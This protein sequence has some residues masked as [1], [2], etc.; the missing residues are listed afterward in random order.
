MATCNDLAGWGILMPQ[1]CPLAPGNRPMGHKPPPCVPLSCP[2]P[3]QV[4]MSA[5]LPARRKQGQW[6][7]FPQA[8]CLPA[9]S[10]GL[11]QPS[12]T[13]MLSWVCL[14]DCKLSFQKTYRESGGVLPGASVAESKL[15]LHAARQASKSGDEGLRQGRR[16]CSE[17]WQTEKTAD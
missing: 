12:T 3:P 7:V 6:T 15:P 16:L 2:P 4:L 8:H 9:D 17:S 5:S 13:H 11:P 1:V 10:G 14:S